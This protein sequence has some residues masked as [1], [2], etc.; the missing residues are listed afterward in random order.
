[1]DAYE[2]Y[3]RL[4]WSFQPETCSDV[5]PKK[6]LQLDNTSVIRK[7]YTATFA[8]S[9]VMEQ[10]LKKNASECLV[11]TH[12]PKQQ[13]KQ[14]QDPPPELDQK[15]I[16]MM[17]ERKISLFSYHIPLD[18]NG[19]FSPGN[20]LA[21]AINAV[22]FDSFYEQNEV[23]MGVI[24][25]T[26]YSTTSELQKALTDAVGHPTKLYLYGKEHLRGNRI[27]IMAGGAKSTSVYEQLSHWET[28]I[29]ITGVTDPNTPWVAKIHEAAKNSGVS[30]LGGTHYST[31]KFALI[32]IC[33]YFNAL[34]MPSEFI[35]ETPRLEEL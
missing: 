5:F 4:E 23:R 1:M 10:L 7:V 12:H 8:S 27:A 21:K 14:T 33:R 9:E 20:S 31:E 22:P 16:D 35:S 26:P 18:R 13:R 30:L 19:P 2:L 11:F 28:D 34:G 17:K 6:G 24:C 3:Q 32:E 29:M 15:W 25:T